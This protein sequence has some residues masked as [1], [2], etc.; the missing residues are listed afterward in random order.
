NPA[1]NPAGRTNLTWVEV[2]SDTFIYLD[3]HGALNDSIVSLPE[4]IGKKITVVESNTR[5]VILN[6]VV[7]SR[8]DVI[9]TA[10]ANN[11][12]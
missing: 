3:Y 2:G 11:N 10:D 6:N 9:S 8:I 4:W 12:G 7:A 5:A 1:L